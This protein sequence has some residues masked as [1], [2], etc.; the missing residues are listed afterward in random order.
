MKIFFTAILSFLLLMTTTAAAKVDAYRNIL[1]SG[2]FTIKYTLTEPLVR[3]TNREAKL[4]DMGGF[5]GDFKMID[6]SAAQNFTLNNHN[7]VV[8]YDGENK[9]Y[10]NFSPF[11][12]NWIMHT[13]KKNGET[14]RYYSYRFS[15]T[16]YS[17]FNDNKVVANMEEQM[18]ILTA[19]DDLNEDYSYGF[20][21]LTKALAPILPPD[22]VIATP[23]TPEYKFIGSGTLNGGL[24]YEDFFR[25]QERL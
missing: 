15:S 24:S 5:G 3:K 11:H 23:Y 18:G 4:I 21:L 9:Y 10:E 2:R 16:Y 12:Q 8:V 13:L 1:S 7:C 20:P 14:F 19:L 25:Q 6:T 22:K 17:I